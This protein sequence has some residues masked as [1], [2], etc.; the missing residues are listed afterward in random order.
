MSKT[1]FSIGISLDGFIAG[2]NR[3]PANP[4]GDR[5]ITIH[6]WAFKQRS[7]LEALELPGGESGTTND[8]MIRDIISRTGAHI[9]GMRMF[10]EG[11]VN[12]PENAPFHSAV[13]VLTN[14]KR[15]PWE[16]KG[17][18][19]FYFVND[20]IEKALQLAKNAAGNK[21]VRISG[22]AQTI[23]QYLDAGLIDEF[24]LHQAPVLLGSG[25]HLFENLDM[26]RI[27]VAPVD[28]INT[29]QVT[30]IRYKYKKS[31]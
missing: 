10:E 26:D 9:M 2:D 3:G 5:G 27:H 16:R 18:T 8:N 28:S 31:E 6:E 13:F 20:G 12:W 11:E 7:F 30:H 23:Q 19:T 21:D 1:F 29:P 25:L 17:G 15:A 14:K 4:L 24:I 22:G